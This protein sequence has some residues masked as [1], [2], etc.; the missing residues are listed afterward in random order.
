MTGIGENFTVS[1]DKSRLSLE[2]T[3]QLLA[4]SHW[5]FDRPREKIAASIANSLCYGVYDHDEQIGFARV[6]TDFA[7]TYWL[8]D[9]IVAPQYRGRGLGERLVRYI[10]GSAE[11]KDLTGVLKTK[12]A[13]G[14]YEKFGFQREPERMMRKDPP[15][16]ATE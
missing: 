4:Q 7:T 3:A 2:K 11:L 13:H 1:C 15:A 16:A 6:I 10:V 12:D 8:C 9:V 14:L 5:A